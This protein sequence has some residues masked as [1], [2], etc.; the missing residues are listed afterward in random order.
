MEKKITA[1]TDE[2]ASRIGEQII[3]QTYTG[4]QAEATMRFQADAARMAAQGYFPVFQ[5]WAPGQWR[6]GAFIAALLLCFL[7]VGIPAL[8][9]ML[10]L[11]PDGVLT[12][13][14]GLGSAR[15]GISD[16]SGLRTSRGGVND[17]RNG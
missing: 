3:V 16:P 7:I 10:I 11:A 1:E 12:V 15:P 13:T 5:S 2:A 9:Y 8:I 6:S 17:W 14:Y 4:S